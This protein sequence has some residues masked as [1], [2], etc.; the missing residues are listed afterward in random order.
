VNGST[1]YCTVTP[2]AVEI[3]HL[4]QSNC[5]Q[6][7]ENAVVTKWPVEQGGD[8]MCL[9]SDRSQPVDVQAVCILCTLLAA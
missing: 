2:G 3:V 1:R 7:L 4:W 8:G 5:P 6:L 9:C